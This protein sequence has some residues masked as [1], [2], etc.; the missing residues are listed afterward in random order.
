[1]APENDT[2]SR[3]PLTRTRILYAAVDLVDR[4]GLDALTM[5]RLGAQLGVEAMALYKHVAN[6]D[7]ILDGILDLVVAEIEPPIE[8]TE[9]KIAM[10]RRAVSAR[11]IFRRHSWAVGLLESRRSLG[12]TVLRYLDAILGNLRSAGFATEDAIHTFW[13]LDSYVYGH[14]IQETSMPLRTAGDPTAP[15]GS[16]PEQMTANEYPHLMEAGEHAR[17][18]SY[19]FDEEFEFG[20]DLI[21][22]AL[23]LTMASA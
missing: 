22:D 1:M 2:S 3:Q 4:Q 23:E 17:T 21:L 18:S 10:R 15:A 8:G 5:R 12:P 11:E 9:W 6:K 16:V 19:G 14:V 13:I 7:D 20:L